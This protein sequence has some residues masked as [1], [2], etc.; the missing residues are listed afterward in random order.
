MR[1]SA[2]R[3]LL[4]VPF[5]LIALVARVAVPAWGD[6]IARRASTL[7]TALHLARPAATSRRAPAP[8]PF[9]PSAP[10]DVGAPEDP[11]DAALPGVAPRK[12]DVARPGPV[13]VRVP[14]ATV[15]WAIDDRGAHLHAR[16]ARGADGRPAGIRLSGVSGLGLGLRDGDTIVAVEGEPALDEE[17]A[18][19][20]ALSAIARGGATLH[21]TVMRGERTFPITAEL[22]LAPGVPGKAR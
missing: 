8:D 6:R 4:A 14:A 19:D 3:A 22:P 20:I 18:T 12:R 2:A 7:V 9:P 1:V 21:A 16:T 10:E 5:L 11:A 17:A 15:Q 13:A